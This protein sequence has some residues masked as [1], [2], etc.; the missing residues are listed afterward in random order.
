[1]KPANI[2]NNRRPFGSLLHGTPPISQISLYLGFVDESCCFSVFCCIYTSSNKSNCF[3][4]QVK[5]ALEPNV[6]GLS[7]VGAPF[8]E[9]KKN[10]RL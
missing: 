7:W 10:S 2:L 4:L 1:M 6:L 8:K 9:E 3:L 5:D